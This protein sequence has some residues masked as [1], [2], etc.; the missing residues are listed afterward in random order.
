MFQPL[1][2]FFSSGLAWS[3]GMIWFSEE[4][5]LVISF[6]L[7]CFMV[8]QLVKV[9]FAEFVASRNAQTQQH[10]FVTAKQYLLRDLRK[11]K[12]NQGAAGL[13]VAQA[14]KAFL[15]QSVIEVSRLEQYIQV[16]KLQAATAS[17]KDMMHAEQS[18]VKALT[19]VAF[20]SIQACLEK[21]LIL[22]K[23][24]L[25]ADI[26]FKINSNINNSFI[27]AYYG[28]VSVVCSKLQ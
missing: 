15:I 6:L 9:D 20:S 16:N 18:Y 5:L 24:L 10:V 2:F 27:T 22:K 11:Q 23:K 17:I 26:I 4:L 19:I 14:V 7:F 8:N 3:Y 12:E 21:E 25:L 28:L 1:W 13:V